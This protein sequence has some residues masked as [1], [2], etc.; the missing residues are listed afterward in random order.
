MESIVF[1]YSA[2]TIYKFIDKNTV[3]FDICKIISNYINDDFKL[4]IEYNLINAH[5]PIS[6]DNKHK[7]YSWQGKYT[8][9]TCRNS[10]LNRIRFSFTNIKGS[11]LSGLLFHYKHNDKIMSDP[12]HLDKIIDEQ[13]LLERQREYALKYTDV[14]SCTSISHLINNLKHGENYKF[15]DISYVR[16]DKLFSYDDKVIRDAINTLSY[17]RVQENYHYTDKFKMFMFFEKL[18]TKCINYQDKQVK[19]NLENKLGHKQ[20][21][22]LGHMGLNRQENKTN[23]TKLFMQFKDK[24]TFCFLIQ[25]IDPVVRE[26]E[27]LLKYACDCSICQC[28]GI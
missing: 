8:Q 27:M 1:D 19:F 6:N 20:E 12:D 15:R 24:N 2:R 5:K 9:G 3:P 11:P 13:F 22:K 26:L 7:S 4:R 18:W 14:I 10:K 21:N 16:D 25:D 23:N 28:P 17:F